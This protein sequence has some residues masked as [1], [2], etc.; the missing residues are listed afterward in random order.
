MQAHNPTDLRGEEERRKESAEEQ[1]RRRVQ[2][3][4][5][6]GWLMSDERGRRFIWRQLK[7]SRVF[8]SSYSV[9]A[10]EMAFLEGVRNNGL[11]LHAEVVALGIE[12]YVR[13]LAENKGK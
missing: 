10:L 9:Q 3:A 5:D 2:E 13:M 7:L 6:L 8:Q 4:A 11:A 12:Q 1:E